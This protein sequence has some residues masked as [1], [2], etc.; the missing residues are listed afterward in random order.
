[1][2]ALGDAGGCRCIGASERV[3]GKEHPR[4]LTS[5]NNLAECLRTLE[6][7]AGALKPP[8][9]GVGMGGG[10]AGECGG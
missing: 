1:M 7:S 9:V 5:V 10:W 8:G 4:T 6:D 2:R 3:L